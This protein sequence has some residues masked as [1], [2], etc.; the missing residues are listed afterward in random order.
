MLAAGSTVSSSLP[1]FLDPGRLDRLEDPLAAALRVVV[2]IVQLLHP[3]EEVGEA[4]G[5][6]VAG[7]DEVVALKYLDEQKLTRR[8]MK[9]E[10]L[11]APNISAG[12]ENY[13][14]ATGED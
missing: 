8:P 2:E 7:F 12:L 3:L 13:L 6:G 11:F 9:V 4:D 14:K 10:E 1:G 5:L